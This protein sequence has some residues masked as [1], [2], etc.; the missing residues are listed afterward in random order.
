[1]DARI[2]ENANA[3]P[4]PT[5]HR[6]HLN[7]TDI[8]IPE[9]IA[10]ARAASVEAPGTL[11]GDGGAFE[12]A[13]AEAQ[14]ELDACRALEPADTRAMLAAADEDC[15]PHD[16]DVPALST[17]QRR[18]VAQEARQSIAGDFETGM[19]A[20]ACAWLESVAGANG[21]AG[22]IT[23]QAHSGQKAFATVRLD[24]KDGAANVA[25]IDVVAAPDSELNLTLAF[26]SPEA[27]A[28]VVG[29][30]VRVFAGAR[31]RVSVSSISTLDGSWALLDD[32]GIVA[33]DDAHVAIAHRVLG[34]GKSYTGLA[35]DLRGEGARLEADTRYLG[36]G[37]ETRD[38][39]YVVR[40]RGRKTESNLIANGVLADESQKVYRGTIDLVHGC[41]GSTG[42]ERETVL[43]ADERVQN[44]TIPVILCDEDDV[45]GN[46]GATIGHVRPEQLN[47]LMTRG[48]SPE[49]AE[50]LFANAALEEAALSSHDTRIRA[51]VRRLAATL[52]VPF[53]L[54][55]DAPAEPI[56]EG[57]SL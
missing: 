37:S 21:D 9:G 48:I 22:A 42:T 25:A 4:A 16:L 50:H 34:A 38:F 57:A 11:I 54:V 8:E 14:A 53:E 19:G 28:G 27:G 20:D 47:Y 30:R 24:G 17:H 43:L 55:E 41:K 31:S 29:S 10:P 5:W 23:L 45:A 18:A 26:D 44:K 3:M 40:H 51:G 39:N 49:A 1:M 33:C 6:M 35:C 12:A 13:L 32:T 7:S 56:A 2:L 52:G 15:D 46:H 36:H